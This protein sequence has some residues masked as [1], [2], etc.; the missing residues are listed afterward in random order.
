M[1]ANRGYE[2]AWRLQSL[3]NLEQLPD[4][5]EGFFNGRSTSGA[6]VD[7][8]GNPVL[9]STPRSWA[10]AANDGERWRWALAQAVETSAT[11]K[12]EVRWQ[13]AN[14]WQSQFGVQTMAYY[15]RFFSTQ[16]ENDDTKK[17]ESETYARL[18]R[19]R[20]N[21]R[22]AGHGHQAVQAGRRIQFHQDLRPNRSRAANRYG[23]EALEQLAQIFE[24]RRQYDR[25]AEFWRQAIKQYGP[26]QNNYRP[27]RLAQIVDN[28]GR[29]EPVMSQPAGKGA[30]VEFRFR[31]GKQV[32]FEAQRS[33]SPSCSTTSKRL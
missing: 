28:W 30:T 1:L 6:A 22:A 5:D 14:F 13:L 15:G 8:D 3:T 11:R 26:G 23:A 12:N 29:F 19:R 9:Y 18:A 21:D 2:E 7:A 31:N 27:Q 17:D 25:A 33:M 20:R 16:Q 32:A 24:N 4:Y 10:K